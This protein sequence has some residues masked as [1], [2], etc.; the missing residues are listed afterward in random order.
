MG[1]L[2][3]IMALL[4]ETRSQKNVVEVIEQGYFSNVKDTVAIVITTNDAWQL[5]YSYLHSNRVPIP[6]PPAFNFETGFLLFIGLGIHKTSGY[7]INVNKF[8]IKK[9]SLSV[10]ATEI[11]PKEGRK[12]QIITTPYKI[13]ALPRDSL[14]TYVQIVL[15]LCNKNIKKLKAQRAES[16]LGKKGF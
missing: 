7:R 5:F 1:K 15:S 14:R 9:D 16:W 2:I 4:C 6:K 11:C 8:S 12:L 3:L 13:I 10:Y